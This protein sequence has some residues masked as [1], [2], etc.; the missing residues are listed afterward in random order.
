MGVEGQGHLILL[1][2]LLEMTFP[3]QAVAWSGCFP[4]GRCCTPPSQ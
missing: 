2:P 1:H 4:K 3:V